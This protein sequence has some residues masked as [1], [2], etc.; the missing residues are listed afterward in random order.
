MIVFNVYFI[1]A[2]IVGIFLTGCSAAKDPDIKEHIRDVWWWIAVVG[3]STVWPVYVY[4]LLTTDYS[5]EESC[6]NEEES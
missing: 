3:L 6:S 1:I 4:M 5:D 2:V